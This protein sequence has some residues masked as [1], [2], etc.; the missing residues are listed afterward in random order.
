MCVRSKFRK[1]KNRK[2]LQGKA[3]RGLKVCVGVEKYIED[4]GKKKKGKG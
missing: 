4:V 2:S 3:I 1:E